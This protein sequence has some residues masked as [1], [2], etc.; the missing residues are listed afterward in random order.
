LVLVLSS[1]LFIYDAL[2]ISKKYL[3]MNSLLSS[4]WYMLDKKRLYLS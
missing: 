4:L 2:S 3:G 1:P